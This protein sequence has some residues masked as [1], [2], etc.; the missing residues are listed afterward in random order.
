M[1][2]AEM[3]SCIYDV[4]T[5]ISPKFKAKWL[6]GTD[7]GVISLFILPKVSMIKE[8]HLIETTGGILFFI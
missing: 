5:H 2:F 3:H 1:D 4:T 7:R 6:L 8:Y